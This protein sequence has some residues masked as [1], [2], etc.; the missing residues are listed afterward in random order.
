MGLVPGVGTECKSGLVGKAG[1][2]SLVR[3]STVKLQVTS[4]VR[5]CI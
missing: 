5:Y 2:R 3:P 1:A 4:I